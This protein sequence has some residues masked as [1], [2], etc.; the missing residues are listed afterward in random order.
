M[1]SMKRFDGIAE[2]IWP[3]RVSPAWLRAHVM[4]VGLGGVGSWVVEALARSGVGALTL[5]D[6][7]DV[8]VSNINRQ[9]HAVEAAVGRPKAAVMAERV[10]AIHPGCRVTERAACFLCASSADDF[11]PEPYDYVVDAADGVTAKAT[12]IGHARRRGITGHHLR[13]GRRQGGPRPACSVADLDRGASRPPAHVHPQ[14]AAQVPRLSRRS[15]RKPFGVPA[16]F[17]PEAVRV[18]ASCAV[19]EGGDDPALFGDEG[20]RLACDGRLGAA[21][22]V[23]GVFG[24]L[25]AARVVN[26]LT[27]RAGAPSRA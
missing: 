27:T 10:R 23:T 7:D 21:T 13:R 17:S 11:F 25:V 3:G 1:N 2:I 12:L 22:F 19:P 5:V 14:A 20:T 15:G 8:C 6:G 4:V 16:V 24:F 18:G 26:D 9:L